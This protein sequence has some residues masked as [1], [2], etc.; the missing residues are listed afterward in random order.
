MGR[1]GSGKSATGNTILG[2]NAF[3]QR[4]SAQAVTLTCSREAETLNEKNVSVIDMPGV[5]DTSMNE[6]QLHAQLK[7]CARLSFPGLHVFLLVIRLD[8]TLSDEEKNIVRW[9]TSYFGEDAARYTFILFTHDDQLNGL[10]LDDFIRESPDHQALINSCEGRYH[11]FN[12]KNRENQD[13][14]FE[15][16]E[17][18]ERMM[19]R[20]ITHHPTLERF[21]FIQDQNEKRALGVCVGLLGVALGALII[22]AKL[23]Q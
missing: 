8:V 5:F 9:I 16:V 7:T 22:A 19:R 4:F 23:E 6:R 14:V 10:S 3:K 20:N 11:S 18:I 12:N 13:Q 15:L 2:R 21:N 17:K 1:V